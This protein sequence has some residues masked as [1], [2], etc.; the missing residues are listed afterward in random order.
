MR[1]AGYSARM[2]RMRIVLIFI[3]KSQ[4]LRRRRY[5]WKDNIKID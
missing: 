5:R 2:G 4:A 3:G 1:W